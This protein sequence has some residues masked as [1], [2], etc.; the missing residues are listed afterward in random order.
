[1]N[2][3]NYF[4]YSR[5]G[6]G[7]L[8]GPPIGYT[9]FLHVEATHVG[10]AW[11]LNFY[12]YYRIIDN[13]IIEF[14]NGV[15][16]QD[17]DLTYNI[18]GRFKLQEPFYRSSLKNYIREYISEGRNYFGLGYIF[19]KSTVMNESHFRSLIDDISADLKINKYFIDKD[20]GD[21]P[22]R[23]LCEEY[24][25]EII[26]VPEYHHIAECRCPAGYSHRMTLDLESGNWFC[27][28]CGKSGYLKELEEHLS[29]YTVTLAAQK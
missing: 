20:W 17:D 25:F 22:L 9:F 11:E 19:H 18:I 26:P 3:M 1:M 12:F 15:G 10:G 21:I 14:V 6:Y 24:G 27:S 28:W 16:Y 13:A 4:D 7:I 8:P 29:K 23:K 5:E 2:A